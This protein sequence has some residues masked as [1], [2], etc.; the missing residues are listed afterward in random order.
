MRNPYLFRLAVFIFFTTTAGLG[1]TPQDPWLVLAGGQTGSVKAHTTRDDLVRIYG[2]TNVV[3]KDID[4][5][6]GETQPGTVVF[7]ADP[8]ALH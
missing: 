1:Q 4:V 6:E 5:G 8:R 3:D 2:A 7:P